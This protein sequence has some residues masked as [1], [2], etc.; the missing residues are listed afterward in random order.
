[1]FI[2]PPSASIALFVDLQFP[3]MTVAASL[4]LT[5]VG[6][7]GTCGTDDLARALTAVVDI[8]SV[9]L[10]IRLSPPSI[11]R[12]LS[13]RLP[14]LSPPLR[15]NAPALIIMTAIMVDRDGLR[16]D[17]RMVTNLPAVAKIVPGAGAETF[18]QA[19]VTT[20]LAVQAAPL[21]LPRFCQLLPRT[22][23]SL[24]TRRMYRTTFRH[25][26]GGKQPRIDWTHP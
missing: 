14:L 11:G 26:A 7:S 6:A 20:V 5:C 1:M 15:G 24:E 16:V 3:K 22:A 12:L 17:T 8:S 25:P 23:T 19:E 4:R 13:W 9:A 2:L 10:T 18:L 21:G